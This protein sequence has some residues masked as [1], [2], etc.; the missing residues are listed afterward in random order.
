MDQINV[1]DAKT[2][3]SR[4][5][6][7]VERGERIVIARAGKPIADLVPHSPSELR[8]GTLQGRI[9]FDDSAFAWPAPEIES[10]F[11]GGEHAA[12]HQ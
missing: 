11:Y 8:F 1:H 2:N 3:L 12:R 6:E 5:L 10:M 9:S 4:I 7:R